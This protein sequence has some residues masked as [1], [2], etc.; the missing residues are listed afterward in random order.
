MKVWCLLVDHENRPTGG[1]FKVQVSS[2][3]D[4][5]DLKEMVKAK[6]PRLLGDMD[7][8]ELDVWKCTDSTNDFLDVS[9]QECEERVRMVFVANKVQCLG[10]R[11]TVATLISDGEVLLVKGPGMCISTHSSSQS[12]YV[13]MVPILS[14]TLSIPTF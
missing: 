8:Y 6:A 2:E 13:L 7:A 3:T 4:V 9:T 10:V 12:A 5:A 14:Q 1:L 11:R